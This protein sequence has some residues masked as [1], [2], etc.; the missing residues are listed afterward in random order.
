MTR[1]YSV[2]AGTRRWPVHVFYNILDLGMINAHTIYNILTEKNISR[3]DF[4]FEAADELAD[5]WQRSRRQAVSQEP[6]QPGGKDPGK[7]QSRCQI[8]INCKANNGN[9]TTKVCSTCK[10][11]VFKGCQSTVV[12]CQGCATDK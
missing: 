9:K 5:P 2:R 6:I 8:K 3:R 1:Q 7:K 11:F 4:I 12:T 10:K